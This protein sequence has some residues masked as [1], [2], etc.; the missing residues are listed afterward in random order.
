LIIE[1]SG[2]RRPQNI[3]IRFRICNTGKYILF[4]E[5]AIIF[6]ERTLDKKFKI[7]KEAMSGLAMIYRKHLSNPNGV[8]E[9]T[10]NAVKWIKAGLEKTRF[11]F[12]PSPV[13]FFGYFGFFWVFF[14]YLPR[15]ESF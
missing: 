6:Q 3:R 1:G 14:S 2:F 10:K 5:C 12:K 15:R 9:A 11:F 4:I 7:R 8:P 13:V